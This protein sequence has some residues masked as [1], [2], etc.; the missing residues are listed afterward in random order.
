MTPSKISDLIEKIGRTFKNTDLQNLPQIEHDMLMQ[1]LR[2]LYEELYLLRNE[3]KV[4]PA[5]DLNKNTAESKNIETEVLPLKTTFLSNA[6][7]L[8]NEVQPTK[9]ETS[10]FKEEK[11]ATSPPEVSTK[12]VEKSEKKSSAS[13]INDN[14]KTTGSLN[15]KL[16]TGASNEVHKKLSSRP[17][18][19]LIDLNNRF[20]LLTELFK[21]NAEAFSAAIHH[22]DTLENYEKA[23]SFVQSQLAANYYW[24]QS[25]QSTR[26]FM[27]LV[28]QKFGIV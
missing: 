15:E 27:K 18:K 17:L 13:S 23:N 1:H 24:D 19:D 22:I 2:D 28:K 10:G 26:L 11:N 21:G 8:L 16:K 4:A 14:I 20:V 6:L 12:P 3:Q 7:L 9:K 25:A 5:H